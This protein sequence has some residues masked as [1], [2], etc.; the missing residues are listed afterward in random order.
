MKYSMLLAALLAAPVAAQS[1]WLIDSDLDQLFSVDLLNGAVTA[2]GSTAGNGMDTPSDLAFRE[3]TGE[4]FTIDMNSG[5]VG[6]LNTANGAFLPLWQTYVN[7]AQGLAWDPMTQR[8]YL[9]NTNS[10]YTLDP[11]TGATTQLVMGAGSLTTALEVGPDGTLYSVG[12]SPGT[13]F[14]VDKQTGVH[15]PLFTTLA[16]LQGIAIDAEGNW[17]GVNTNTNSLYRIDPTSG[18]ATL[19]GVTTGVVFAK[20]LEVG[21][22]AMQRGGTACADGNNELHRMTCLGSPIVGGVVLL[23]VEPG[24]QP[25]MALLVLGFNVRQYQSVPLPL[26]LSLF[27]MPGCWLYTG[28]QALLGPISPGLP[29]PLVL[30]GAPS[31]VGTTFFVQGLI[32]DPAATPA[33]GASTVFSDYMRVVITR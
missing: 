21:D 15:T 33:N 7:G 9:A 25:T 20:G 11:A 17:Y 3:D 2:L 22:T 23:D 4:L 29:L 32:A 31:L 6:R 10:V 30:P 19:V 5:L 16:Y 28:P 14:T 26:D 18:A 1:A 8:F 13:V 24:S 12:F 27:G